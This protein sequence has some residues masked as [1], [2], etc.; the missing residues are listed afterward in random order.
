MKQTGIVC[1]INDRSS[2]VLA[3]KQAGIVCAINDRSSRVL[4]LSKQALFDLLYYEK[5][6]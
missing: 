2:C 4:A 1:A 5:P 3:L 6:I